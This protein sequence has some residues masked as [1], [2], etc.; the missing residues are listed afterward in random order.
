[1][2][3]E[4][5]P[6]AVKAPKAPKNGAS[7]DRMLELA[8]SLLDAAER[9]GVPQDLRDGMTNTANELYRRVVDQINSK[10]AEENPE[11]LE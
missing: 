5:T 8:G 2:K 1:M 6:K 11:A 9:N 10:L 3:P 4:K 7:V